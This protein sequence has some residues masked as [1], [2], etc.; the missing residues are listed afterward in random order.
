MIFTESVAFARKVFDILTEDE[1]IA[2]EDLLMDSPDAG[3]IIPGSRGLRKI[4]VASRGKGKRGGS[5]VIYYWYVD[6]EKIQFCRIYEKSDQE[7]LS[8]AEVEQ[9]LT[10]LDP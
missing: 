6:P 4:R 2:L 8:K 1:L 9:I 3:A 10:E 7:N 5:R